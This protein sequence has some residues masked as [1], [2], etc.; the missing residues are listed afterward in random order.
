MSKRGW[1]QVERGPGPAAGGRGLGLGGGGP[2]SPP[3]SLLGQAAHVACRPSG[4]PLSI[5]GGGRGACG[6][7]TPGHRPGHARH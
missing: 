2:A 4:P 5:V 1:L 6:E 3:P 7:G